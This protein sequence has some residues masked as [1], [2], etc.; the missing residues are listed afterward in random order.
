MVISLFPLQGQEVY[1]FK[2]SLILLYTFQKHH[3]WRQQTLLLVKKVFFKKSYWIASES[4][5]GRWIRERHRQASQHP[6]TGRGVQGEAAPAVL[7]VDSGPP[8]PGCQ[9]SHKASRGITPTAMLVNTG[10]NAL[11]FSIVIMILTKFSLYFKEILPYRIQGHIICHVTVLDCYLLFVD[12]I[13]FHDK[14]ILI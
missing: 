13:F 1:I 14:S 4:S 9:V 5:G 8:G 10:R 2:T 7:Q 12:F 6:A 11:P 3:S